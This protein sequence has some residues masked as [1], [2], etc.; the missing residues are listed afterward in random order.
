[1][2]TVSPRVLELEERLSQVKEEIAKQEEQERRVSLVVGTFEKLHRALEGCLTEAET[3]VVNGMYL[4]L[5]IDRAG[6][7][8][9]VDMVR[10]IPSTTDKGQGTQLA[11]LLEGIEG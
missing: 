4:F 11:K 2:T 3:Q 10:N 8:L 5:H 7:G 6:N 9:N 1:M